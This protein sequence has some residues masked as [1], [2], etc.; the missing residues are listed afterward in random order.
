MSKKQFRNFTAEQKSKI[1]LEL[2]KE[3]S[4]IAQ[5]GS[6]YEIDPRTLGVWEEAVFKQCGIGF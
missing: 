4:T 5:V 1:V 3:E 6:K 2:L